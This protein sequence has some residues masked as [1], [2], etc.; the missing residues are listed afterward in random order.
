MTK[1][2]FTVEHARTGERRQVSGKDL[3]GALESAGLTS[4]HWHALPKAAEKGENE[5]GTDNGNADPGD[6]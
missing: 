1:K 4:I 5:T 6:N 3:A 2:T